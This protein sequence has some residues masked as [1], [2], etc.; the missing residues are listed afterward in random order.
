MIECMACM[1]RMARMARMANG[2]TEIEHAE[3]VYIFCQMKIGDHWQR[4]GGKIRY[5]N[6]KNDQK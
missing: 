3:S 6:I 2:Y 5:G 4:Q 1:A